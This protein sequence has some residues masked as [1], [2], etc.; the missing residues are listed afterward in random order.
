MT[1]VE[2]NPGQ[3]KIVSDTVAGMPLLHRVIF[4]ALLAVLLVAPF[5]LYPVFLMKVLCFALFASAS[6]C[7]S[8]SAGCCRSDTRPISAQRAT[9]RPMP[10]R[11]GG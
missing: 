3:Q 9:S 7:C 4:I 1:D 2:P 11:S 8:V 5:Q 10:Q 6:T